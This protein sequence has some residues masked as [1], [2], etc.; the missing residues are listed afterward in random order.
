MIEALFSFLGGS[1]FRMIWGEVSA[2]YNKRQDH[3][4]EL[5]RLRLQTEIDDRAHQRNQE[6]LRLQSELG[7]KTIE[8]KMEADVATAEADAF[9]KA[10][11]S[12]F[13]PTGWSFVDIWN[14]II[15][16]TAATIALALWVMKL[17][18]Q[19]WMMQEWDIT[20][21]GTV[22]GFFFADRSLGKRGK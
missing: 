14:G 9:V 15:R 5:E 12:A 22:L 4:F 13:K 10:M 19:N 8:A 21:A 11:E 7:I 1:V 16:P 17:H 3:T 18:S 6:A 2:W 20:L